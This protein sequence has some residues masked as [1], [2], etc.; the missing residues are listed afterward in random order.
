[1]RKRLVTYRKRIDDLLENAPE[2]T[3]WDDTIAEHLVQISFFQHE[4]LIHLLVTLAFALIEIACVVAAVVVPQP[5]T[6]VLMLLV[7]V[8][9]VPY[10]VH[11]YFLENET[12][13]LY[14]QYDAL[15]ARA[16]TSHLK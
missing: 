6:A 5:L 13:K 10:I 11:Y 9:L 2:A 7:L 8:L 1:M 12:Q 15:L 4:R 3:D 16:R 14:A